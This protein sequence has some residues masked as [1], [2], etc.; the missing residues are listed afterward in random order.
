MRDATLYIAIYLAMSQICLRFHRIGTPYCAHENSYLS[1]EGI[2]GATTSPI[3]GAASAVFSGNGHRLYTGTRIVRF[4]YGGFID[5]E[6]DFL[7]NSTILQWVST[8]TKTITTWNSQVL[9]STSHAEQGNACSRAC[10][11]TSKFIFVCRTLWYFGSISDSDRW[12]PKAYFVYSCCM[13]SSPTPHLG[14]WDYRYRCTMI[15]CFVCSVAMALT[16]ELRG[17]GQGTLLNVLRPLKN[18]TLRNMEPKVTL[19][20]VPHCN[21]NAALATSVTIRTHVVWRCS[22]GKHNPA[23]TPAERRRAALAAAQQRA[24]QLAGTVPQKLYGWRTVLIVILY[25]VS[26]E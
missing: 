25:S 4:Q 10:S 22:T 1:S 14:T 7:W 15:Y 2:S 18:T 5:V 19:Q 11:H 12:R 20:K 21:T 13:V 8:K 16:E 23:A 24:G 3:S 26:Q 9:Q 17:N 6:I